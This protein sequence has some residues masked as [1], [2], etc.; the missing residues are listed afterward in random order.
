MKVRDEKGLANKSDLQNYTQLV[1]D[2]K[3]TR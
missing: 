1:N 3:I 2:K